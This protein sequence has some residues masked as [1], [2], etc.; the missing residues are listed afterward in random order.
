M[1]NFFYSCAENS[2]EETNQKNITFDPLPLDISYAFK[3]VS[4]NDS[5][6][7]L[8]SDDCG[9]ENLH[10]NDSSMCQV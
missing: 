1:I 3:S 8:D 6:P 5:L 10:T 4:E 7:N 9:C 2:S